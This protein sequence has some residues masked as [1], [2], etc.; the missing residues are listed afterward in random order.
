MNRNN[1]HIE[2]VFQKVDGK[3]LNTLELRYDKLCF[4]ITQNNEIYF[5]GGS[6]T[7]A[8]YLI[9]EFYPREIYGLYD[10][11]Q[12]YSAEIVSLLN[13]PQNTQE[14]RDYYHDLERRMRKVEL[15]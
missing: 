11:A 6:Y 14:Y 5:K 7:Q 12:K 1:M 10:V 13:M 3:Y 15:S 2:L 4:L 9:F 8:K